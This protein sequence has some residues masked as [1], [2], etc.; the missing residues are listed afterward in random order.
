MMPVDR[1]S[2]TPPGGSAR[3]FTFRF[4]LIGT[5]I[6]VHLVIFGQALY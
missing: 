6:D 4:S 2:L 1:S 3:Y 5:C